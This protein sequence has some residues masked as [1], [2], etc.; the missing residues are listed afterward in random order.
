[1]PMLASLSRSEYKSIRE[2]E[3]HTERETER[4]GRT[5]LARLDRG[6][7]RAK[8]YVGRGLTTLS[9]SAKVSADC[10]VHV[11]C[12]MGSSL[13]GLTGLIGWSSVTQ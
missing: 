11:M 1:M 13:T 7:F 10:I 12:R 2:E 3:P 4:E 5:W 9:K 6:S 8:K